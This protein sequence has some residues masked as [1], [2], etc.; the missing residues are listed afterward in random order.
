MRPKTYHALA[1]FALLVSLVQLDLLI[2][3]LIF[4][5]RSK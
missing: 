3:G 4:F 2:K 1:A 5:L